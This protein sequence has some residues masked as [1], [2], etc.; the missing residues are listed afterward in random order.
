[1]LRSRTT[2]GWHVAAPV[3]MTMRTSST[4]RSTTRRL[5]RNGAAIAHNGIEH[6]RER[7]LMPSWE[8]RTKEEKFAQLLAGG[9]KP[10]DAFLQAGFTARNA[11]TVRAAAS[12]L[13][14]AMEGRV[15]AIIGVG[16]LPQMAE[17]IAIS[18]AVQETL[19]K[20]REDVGWCREKLHELIEDKDCPHH[21]RLGAIKEC[22]NRALGLP[23]QYVE[24][25]LNVR[26]QISDR[27][28]TEEEWDAKYCK[29][30]D[31]TPTGQ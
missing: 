26:Y 12:R 20:F 9:M 28:M 18:T 27:E 17:P 1:M 22:L 21:T 23:P 4:T 11:D 24:Q 31:L 7:V 10:A 14:K 6:M 25:N 13:K 29:R 16:I 2:A 19:A 8:R 15:R 5:H 3:A 30:I